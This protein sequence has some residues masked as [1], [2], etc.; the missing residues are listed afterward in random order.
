V[1]KVLLNGQSNYRILNHIMKFITT[2][3]IILLALGQA[4][5]LDSERFEFDIDTM[6]YLDFMNRWNKRPKNLREFLIA[7]MEFKRADNFI[8]TYNTEEGHLATMEHNE[9][10]DWTP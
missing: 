6:K 8:E 10:S 1:W 2:I 3:L 5:T 7:K 4:L 9:Y